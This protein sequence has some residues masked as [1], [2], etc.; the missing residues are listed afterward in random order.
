MQS[1]YKR[2]PIKLAM[3]GPQKAGK[4]SVI[5][6]FH[7]GTF[8][9]HTIAT[10]GASFVVHVFE[11]EGQQISCQIWDTAGQ[12]KYRSLGPIYYRDAVCALSM[13]DLTSSE[14]FDEM[15]LFLNQ[16]CDNCS[17]Y[18]HIA[19]IGNKVDVYEPES[20]VDIDTVKNWALGQGWSFHLTSALTGQGVTDLFQSS[21]ELVAERMRERNQV[22]LTLD[23]RGSHDDSCC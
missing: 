23:S 1:P 7:K 8:D 9:S 13:F 5:N 17:D 4:T 22:T 3:I 2:K 20:G 15:K 16:F 11:V 6:R 18:V 14:S 21:V 12:E 10:V 19:I